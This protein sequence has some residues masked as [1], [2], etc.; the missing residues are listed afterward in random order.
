MAKKSKELEPADMD[1]QSQPAEKKPRK[2]KESEQDVPKQVLLLEYS[3]TISKLV[4]VVVLAATVLLSVLNGCSWLT[5]AIRAGSVTLV[6]GLILYGINYLISD[7]TLD[8]I[9]RQ[10]AAV[11]DEDPVSS[12]Q[13]WKV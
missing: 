1:Q 6:L 13:E 8:I 11:R 5:S 12:T 9:F 7:G 2:Q 10:V 3:F 4:I